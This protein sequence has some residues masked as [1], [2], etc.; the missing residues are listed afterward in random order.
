M[1]VSEQF[2]MYKTQTEATYRGTF[3]GD[4]VTITKDARPVLTILY[5]IKGVQKMKSAALGDE[6]VLP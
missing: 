5:R 6:I 2:A 4:D 3:S 1:V